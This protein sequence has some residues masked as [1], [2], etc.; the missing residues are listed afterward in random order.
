MSINTSIHNVDKVELRNVEALDVYGRAVF[1]RVLTIQSSDG[2]KVE[3]T[4]FS[5]YIA[6]LKVET[7]N[8]Y[9]PV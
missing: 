6:H 5:D 1:T 7:E 9:E 4:L 2:D 8:S 3:I